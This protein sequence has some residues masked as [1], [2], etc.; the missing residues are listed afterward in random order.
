MKFS[1]VVPVYNVEPFL[2]DCL[3][4]ILTQNYDDYEVICVNDAST[5]NSLV[6]LQDFIKMNKKIPNKFY[7]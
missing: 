4:S 3:E 1:I 6:I 7:I 5:D 2:G